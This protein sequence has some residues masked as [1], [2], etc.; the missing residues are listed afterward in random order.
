[1]N[2]K[3]VQQVITDYALEVANLKVAVATIQAELEELK[4]AQT[5][6]ETKEAE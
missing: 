4:A 6:E 5:T 2:E 3:A 1:M